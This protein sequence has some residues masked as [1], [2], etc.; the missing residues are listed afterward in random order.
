MAESVLGTSLFTLR[1]PCVSEPRGNGGHFAW[2]HTSLYHTHTCVCAHTQAPMH[3][4]VVI[5]SNNYSQYNQWLQN[6][7]CKL[8]A[9]LYVAM[10]IMVCLEE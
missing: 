6:H 8:E 9:E 3:I 2:A 1:E 7:S 10:D 4:P 5:S